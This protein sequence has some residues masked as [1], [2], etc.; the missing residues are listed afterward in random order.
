MRKLLALLMVTGRLYAQA[1]PTKGHT[2]VVVD[3]FTK[4]PIAGALVGSGNR[5]YLTDDAGRLWY[6]G[7]QTDTLKVWAVGYA[8]S[9]LLRGD[10]LALEPAAV[11]LKEMVLLAATDK[12]MRQVVQLDLRTRGLNNAQEILRMV[13]G[14]FIGQHAGGG[15]AEQ[16]FLRGFDIDHGTDV[17][18]TADGIP[19]N[20]VSHAHGQGYADLHFLIPE[21]VQQVQFGKGPYEADKGNFATAGYVALQSKTHLEHNLVKLEGGQFNTFRSLVMLNLLGKRTKPAQSWYLAAEH[22]GSRGFFDAPQDFRR[23]NLFT[24]YRQPLGRRHVLDLSASTFWSKWNA[25]GQIPERAV[26][27]GSISFFG[28]IDPNEGGHTNRTNI[29]ARLFSTLSANSHL[30]QQLYGTRYGFDLFSNFTFFLNDPVN[31]DQIRQRE[32]RNLWGYQGTYVHQGIAG[33]FRHE[34]R[35]G[36]S[37]RADATSNSE[38]AHTV[39]RTLILQHHQL[40]DIREWNAAAFAEQRL[41]FHQR[42][43]LNGGLR[44]DQFRH[45]YRNR[46]D[47][48]DRKKHTAIV[49]PKINL[50]WQASG[51]LSLYASAGRGFHSND[52]R[53]VVQTGGREALPGAWGTDL[54]VQAKPHSNLLVHAALW[55]LA[56]EQEFVYV[57]DEGVVEPSGRTRRK[58]VDVSVRY[59]PHPALYLDADVNYARPRALDVPKGE[60]FLPL[61]P[62]LTT[63]GGITWKKTQGLNGSLRYRYMGHRPANEDNSIRARGYFICDA[64]VAYT[65]A[66]WELVLSAQNI[67]D[68]RWK[69][70]QFAT[71]SRLQ[72]E[73]A[74][75]TEIHFTPGTPFFLK[76]AAAIRF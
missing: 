36:A 73:T 49:S 53:V 7:R 20:M 17:A 31:G 51:Q 35:T 57:G 59:Q 56:M 18:I 28:A 54:G 48:T 72:H 25:S 6:N 26:A 41:Y 67:F 13:P 23:S 44:L 33:N 70:T 63:A 16:I 43:T 62:Q 15:K 60:D 5:T 55:H 66:R 68:S 22:L 75:V 58:G 50:S 8:P 37:L 47:G 45:Q 21:A 65:Q 34:L 64:V 32:G 12:V 71:T 14:L 76:A 30:E 42:W 46:L 24:R 19:V 3:A 38:L 52:A 27:D 40:G 2:V 11:Q 9:V 29:N 69:E 74:P 10:T 39:N 1:P 4:Q 61:A